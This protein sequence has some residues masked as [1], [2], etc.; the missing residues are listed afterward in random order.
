MITESPFFILS[1]VLVKKF[2]EDFTDKFEVT[3]AFFCSLSKESIVTTLVFSMF[4]ISTSYT[5]FISDIGK[6][7]C[8]SFSI[9]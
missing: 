7:T 9:A 3:I 5:S 8:P 2:V 1:T 6:Y 4:L